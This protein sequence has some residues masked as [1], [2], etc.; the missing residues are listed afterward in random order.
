VNRTR[1]ALTLPGTDAGTLTLCGAAN[2]ESWPQPRSA[3]PPRTCRLWCRFALGAEHA[4]PNWIR[5][6]D[7]DATV[8]TNTK[9]KVYL[10]TRERNVSPFVM[11]SGALATKAGKLLRQALDCRPFAAQISSRYGRSAFQI[12][13]LEVDSARH[14]QVFHRSCCA[15]AWQNDGAVTSPCARGRSRGR[16][17]VTRAGA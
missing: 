1:N 7:S 6:H 15:G 16:R 14:A 11:A 4:D 10:Q 2:R 3:R 5:T 9:R 17:A 8:G 13:N 12:R